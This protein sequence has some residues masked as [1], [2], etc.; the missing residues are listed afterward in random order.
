MTETDLKQLAF[1]IHNLWTPRELEIIKE[2]IE[3]QQRVGAGFEHRMT[4]HDIESTMEDFN[5]PGSRWH[6]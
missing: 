3:R 4:E 5:Y 1:Q 2:M 6:Y